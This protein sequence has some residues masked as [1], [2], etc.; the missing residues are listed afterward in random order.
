[1]TD[2][3]HER[4]LSIIN[5]RTELTVNKLM[6]TGFV[7]AMISSVAYADQAAGSFS[8]MVGDTGCGSNHTDSKKEQIFNANYLNREMTASGAVSD[9]KGDRILIKLLHGTLTY[10]LDVTM[11]SQDG[12]D[13][14][15][16]GSKLTVRF[17]VSSQGGCILPYSG[18][19][20]TIV[21]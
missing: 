10:D 1:M 21:R 12:F 11:A 16:K 14:L 5:K 6:I 7:A 4:F 2:G 8:Q 9:I 13:D 19:N 3:W 18:K 15:D 17:T 20:G